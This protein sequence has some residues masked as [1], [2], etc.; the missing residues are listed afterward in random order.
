MDLRIGRHGPG[1]GAITRQLRALAPDADV[2][3]SLRA[4]AAGPGPRRMAP[5][6]GRAELLIA[7][8]LGAGLGAGLMYLFDPEGG[9]RRRAQA[10]DQLLGLLRQTGDVVNGGS[11]DMV[12][13]A[14]G[15]V[16]E[17]GSRLQPGEVSDALLARRVRARIAGVVAH[18]DGIGIEASAGWVTVSGRV[19]G[20][21]ATPLLD[22]VATVRGV[23]G[24]HNRLEITPTT[25]A[26]SP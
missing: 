1:P 24:V 13:R 16:I 11:R 22:R 3:K 19:P 12:N 18:P 17:I 21:E 23:K 5:P 7:A 10:R 26:R 25:E 6:A 9:R 20:H 8:I 14:R 15:L 2:A 4:L